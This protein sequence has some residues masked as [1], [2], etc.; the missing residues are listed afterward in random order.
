MT[1]GGL[2]G[3]APTGDSDQIG[4]MTESQACWLLTGNA[5]ALQTMLTWAEA[6]GSV[7]FH[8]RDANSGCAPLDVIANPGLAWS[9]DGDTSGQRGMRTIPLPSMYGTKPA[10]YLIPDAAHAPSLAFIPWMLT[11]DPFF[12]EEA[13]METG[14]HLIQEAGAG[15]ISFSQERA[16]AWGLRDL[17]R[18]AAFAPLSPPSWLRPRSYYLACMEANR[19]KLAGKMTSSGS[20]AAFHMIPDFATRFSTFEND[21]LQIVL[22]W[23]LYAGFETWRD[24]VAYYSMQRLVMAAAPALGFG[25]DWRWPLAYQ[26]PFP[27]PLPVNWAEAWTAFLAS[28]QVTI[29]LTTW[30]ANELAYGISAY[31]LG[32]RAA[33]AALSCGSVPSAQAAHDW[34][35]GQA[36]THVGATITDYKWALSPT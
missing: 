18:L 24:V 10:E 32:A 28:G 30:P 36:A 14:Y 27:M 11:D 21:Y 3:G 7:V 34:L 19:I 2:V 5:N 6:D 25:W 31:I 1:D 22:G 9:W 16:V 35:R 33:L 17:S 12:L 15:S 23:V 13:Q 29:D 26:W 8:I 20:A 4:F